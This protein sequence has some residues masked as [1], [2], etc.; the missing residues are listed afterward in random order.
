[1]PDPPAHDDPLARYDRQA[2]FAP[3]GREGQRR[4]AESTVLVVGCGALGSTSADLLVRA[5]VGR[6]RLVDRDFPELS[7]LQRQSLFDEAD[8]A[9]A[10]PK[11]VAAANR[12][13]RVNSAVEVEPVVADLTHENIDRV[14]QGARVVVDGTDNF[15]TR[16]LVNDYAIETGTPWVFGGVVGAEG[17]VLTVLPGQTPCLL[18]LA[19]EPPGP[20]EAPTCDTAGVL[21][22]A[23]NVVASIQ[24][25]EAIKLL[26]GDVAAVRRGLLVVDL[27][28]N[29]TRTLDLAP[30]HPEGSCPACHQGRF[31]WRRGER[32]AHATVLCGR[33]AVQVQPVTPGPVDL[34]RLAGVLAPLGPVTTNAFLTRVVMGDRTLTVFRDGRAIVSGVTD[35]AEARSLVARTLGS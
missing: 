27:W 34:E 25:L 15:E 8:V 35:P 21:G 2:R 24:A 26:V 7:N 9:A 10:L 3:I 18:S 4:L 17:Q 1:M 29:R 23:V 14:A 11:A 16:L 30:L 22:P 31:P 19:P 20:G 33:N 5:G 32:A 28:S 12:L 13:R 6:V